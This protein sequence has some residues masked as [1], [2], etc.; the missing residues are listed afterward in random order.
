[1]ASVGG[2][3]AAT[4]PNGRARLRYNSV[5]IKILC[6]MIPPDTLISIHKADVVLLDNNFYY[7]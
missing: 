1:M 3:S 6:F 5:N 7:Q 4:A 2:S